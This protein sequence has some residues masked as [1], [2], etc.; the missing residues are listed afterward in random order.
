MHFYFIEHSLC[1]VWLYRLLRKILD[2]DAMYVYKHWVKRG[3]NQNRAAFFENKPR[4]EAIKRKRKED[5]E[6]RKRT[7]QEKEAS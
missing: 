5:E 4:R 7:V 2:N 6:R 1:C 3:D